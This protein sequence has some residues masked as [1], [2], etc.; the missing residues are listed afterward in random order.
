[1]T[2]YFR[3]LLKSY[4]LKKDSLITLFK[5]SGGRHTHTQSHSE[6]LP[7]Y[8][9]FFLALIT[10]QHYIIYLSVICLTRL[11]THWEQGLGYV[12]APG[13]MVDKQVV[14]RQCPISDLRK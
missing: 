13:T 11:E 8:F 2:D 7:L 4:F 12:Q 6:L 14:D 9:I 3:F 5:I 10:I 1:M